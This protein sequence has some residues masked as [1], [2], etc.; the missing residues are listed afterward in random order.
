[1]QP[2]KL[3]VKRQ[4]ELTILLL[5][6]AILF[7][8]YVRI[9]PV[10]RAGFPLTDGGLFYTMTSDLVTSGFRLPLL[11]SYNHLNIPFVYP[12]FSLYLTGALHVLTGFSLLGLIRWL[13]VIFSLLTIPAFFLLARELLGSHPQAA[14]ATLIF[15]L[16]PRAYEWI[17]M[18]GGVT[19]A[20]ATLFLILMTWAAYRAFHGKSWKDAILAALFGGLVLLTHPERALHAAATGILFWLWLDRS[21][22]GAVKALAIGMGAL[23]VSSPWWVTALVRY[24]A[25][26]LLLAAQSAGSRWLFWAP[27]LQLDFTDEAVPLAAFLAVLGA[28]V[29]WKQRK[30]L[31]AVW[32]VLAFLAD[33]RSAPHVIA[34]QVSLLATIGLTEIIFPALSKFAF[35]WVDV[36]GTKLGKAVFGYFLIML[37]FNAQSN[38]QLINGLILSSADRQAINWSVSETTAD[39]R[40]LVLDWQSEPMFSPLL[41]WFPAL[42]GRTNVVTIQGREWLPGAA[43]FNARMQTYPDL[44]ACLYQDATCLDIWAQANDETFD[45]V[46]LSLQTP[47]GDLRL[48]RLSDSLRTSL[49][50]HLVYEIPQVLIFQHTP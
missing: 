21:R 24:G 8:A 25:S 12:P 35:D 27:L 17:I 11:T 45:Y 50:Y 10:V 14:F 33:P 30:G 7:G 19:R 23:L 9:F 46:Y 1:M 5:F 32:F 36:F 49:Q 16:L 37:L 22:S 13:P 44:Y 34:M 18:G 3:L 26:P 4:S 31:L 39:S 42:S 20:P 48:S 29:C 6:L 15:A 41:E 43:N 28:F 2:D 40:F 38:L 47:S